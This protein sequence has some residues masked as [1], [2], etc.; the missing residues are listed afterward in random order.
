MLLKINGFDGPVIGF[1]YSTTEQTNMGRLDPIVLSAMACGFVA[2]ILNEAIVQ[3]NKDAG[4]ID[5]EQEAILKAHIGKPI[6]CADVDNLNK[7]PLDEFLAMLYHEKGHLVFRHLEQNSGEEGFILNQQYELQA[8]AYAAAM[9]GKKA[10]RKALM[11]AIY[12]CNKRTFKKGWF[13][14][15]LLTLL[16]IGGEQ[17][18]RFDALK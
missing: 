8:D 12:Q 18:Y 16:A 15:I 14:T 13:K 11:R 9:V 1:S 5:P 2:I 17:K 3:E 6:I 4:K 7:W 10:V